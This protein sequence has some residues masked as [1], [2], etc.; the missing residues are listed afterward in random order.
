MLGNPV[1]E[2]AILT[3]A[4]AIF[5]FAAQKKFVDQDQVKR[6]Q[7]RLKEM[8]SEMK[9]LMKKNDEASLKRLHKIEK[10]MLEATQGMMKGTMKVMLV[11]TP[12][13]F[14]ALWV[15]HTFFENLVVKLPVAI[16]WFTNFDWGNLASWTQFQWYL[17]TNYLGWYFLLY[18][19]TNIG[20]NLLYNGYQKISKAK[21][22]KA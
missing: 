5:S 10:E 22:K 14:G 4:L 7:K 6:D 16:P 3:V 19:M 12:L 2:V 1:L 15:F 21:G 9:E 18:L 20:L 8:Q 13:F 11:T 17:E